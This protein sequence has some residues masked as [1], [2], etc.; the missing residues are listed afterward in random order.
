MGGASI[1]VVSQLRYTNS[2]SYLSRRFSCIA[3]SK[4]SRAKLALADR[5]NRFVPGRREFFLR[6][7]SQLHVR[8]SYYIKLSLDE[9]IYISP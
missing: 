4:R 2:S 8:E 7:L 5:E 1:S 6:F 3:L 9:T